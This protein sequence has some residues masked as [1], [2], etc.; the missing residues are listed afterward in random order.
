MQERECN[1]LID[2]EEVSRV[3]TMLSKFLH[4]E[5][6]TTSVALA[7]MELLKITIREE[8]GVEVEI[9]RLRKDKSPM[10]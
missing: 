7:A 2:S 8:T 3:A 1:G 4:G 6:V 5:R 9:V 10:M